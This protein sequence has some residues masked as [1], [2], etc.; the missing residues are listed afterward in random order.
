MLTKRWAKYLYSMAAPSIRATQFPQL[1]QTIQDFGRDVMAQ[2]QRRTQQAVTT[3]EADEA[4]DIAQPN[5]IMASL[6]KKSFYTAQTLLP[7]KIQEFL[8]VGNLKT[9]KAAGTE[10]NQRASAATAWL[11]EHSGRWHLAASAWT[12]SSHDCVWFILNSNYSE[13]GQGL[14]LC[15][16]FSC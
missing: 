16:D 11:Q 6:N 2:S 8:T 7:Q 12:G 1:R 13:S 3:D 15:L 14:Q 4:D 5:P 9:H 10:S